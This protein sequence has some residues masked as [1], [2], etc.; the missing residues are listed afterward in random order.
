MI[1]DP[2]WLF[3]SMVC[4]PEAEGRYQDTPESCLFPQPAWLSSAPCVSRAWLLKG[5]LSGSGP[6]V[7]VAY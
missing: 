7:P 6:Q 3:L 1:A 5:Y 2:C 4:P